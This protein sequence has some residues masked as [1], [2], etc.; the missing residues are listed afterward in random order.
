MEYKLFEI[1]IT[2]DNNDRVN[3]MKIIIF[4]TY[5]VTRDN[6]GAFGILVSTLYCH[7]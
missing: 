7:Y 5:V 1:K 4:N 6:K 3:K 2:N